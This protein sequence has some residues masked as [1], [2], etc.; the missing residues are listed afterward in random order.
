ME[1]RQLGGD[2]GEILDTV[3]EI[4]D[5]LSTQGPASSSS[6]LLARLTQDFSVPLERRSAVRADIAR[7]SE[8]YSPEADSEDAGFVG[9]IIAKAVENQLRAKTE[10]GS[11]DADSMENGPPDMP[12][13]SMVEARPV[14]VP[15]M[16]N[17]VGQPNLH[18]DM[19]VED[20]AWGGPPDSTPR[21]DWDLI[22][23]VA[24]PE[25]LEQ[26][27]NGAP[28]SNFH[29]GVGGRSANAPRAPA[30][31]KAGN[32]SATTTAAMPRSSVGPAARPSPQQGGRAPGSIFRTSPRSG[33]SPHK[34]EIQKPLQASGPKWLADGPPSGYPSQRELSGTGLEAAGLPAQ[35]RDIPVRSENTPG[36]MVMHGTPGGMVMHGRPAKKDALDD[37]VDWGNE[38]DEQ[39]CQRKHPAVGS[40]SKSDRQPSS[41]SRAT[42]PKISFTLE[43]VATRGTPRTPA[44]SG[45]TPEASARGNE[46]LAHGALLTPSLR[47]GI[48]TSDP[49]SLNPYVEALLAHR[50]ELK[51]DWDMQNMTSESLE[52]RLATSRHDGLAT[53]TA[54]SPPQEFE[55]D[56][57]SR[58]IWSLTACNAIGPCKQQTPC[59]AD[60]QVDESMLAVAALWSESFDA[61]ATSRS[62]R[63]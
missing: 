57:G 28:Q 12:P 59:H 18:V 63:P 54:E 35:P 37:G 34:P 10:V 7:A 6:Q 62:W 58:D 41:S 60:G 14:Q 2:A 3:G 40:P 33:L 25:A 39:G 44:Q 61:L 55:Y 27:M 4:Q 23:K 48:A 9:D 17:S 47:Y 16:V 42:V 11:L 24:G 26:V 46:A 32:T 5:F 45:R 31:V 21:L 30:R 36:G 19:G 56:D 22:E 51:S 29:E 20:G 15:A 50:E 53:L 8:P 13:E 52:A 43:D 49:F 1:N 38:M